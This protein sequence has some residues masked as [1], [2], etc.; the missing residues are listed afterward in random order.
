MAS[1]EDRHFWFV[2]RN[3]IIC[4]ALIPLI[5]QLQTGYRLLEVGCGTGA[6]LSKL[7]HI[8]QEGEVIGMDLHNEAVEVAKKRTPCKV[9][10]GNIL[11]PPELGQFD[12]VGAFD[13]IE[14]LE[15]HVAAL[16]GLSKLLRPGGKILLTVP[17]HMSLWSYFDEA[18]CHKRRYNLH[19][20]VSALK[21]AKLQPLYMT[22]FMMGTFPL[23]WL[24]RRLFSSRKVS[25]SITEQA[26]L[27]L[28]IVP[29][30]NSL[31]KN[32]LLLEKYWIGGHLKLP[33]GSSIIAIA[34][35]CQ[36]F[37]S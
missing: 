8:C 37:L 18:A 15:D 12:I 30:V 25:S 20:L 17:A 36:K 24:G 14:H 28:K 1:I 31:L 11:D 29:I 2:A 19:S 6:L 22:E 23:I 34:Q 33:F 13:V 26:N 9:V 16:M 35:T 27:E 21:S 5:H 32:F 10:S 4:N 7:A 3:H